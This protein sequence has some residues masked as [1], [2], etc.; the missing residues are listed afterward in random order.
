MFQEFNS[1]ALAGAP[2]QAPPRPAPQEAR[3]LVSR[4]PNLSEIELARL[5]NLYRRFS[6]LD[7]ALMISDDAVGPKLDRFVKDHRRKVRS[8]FSHYAFLVAYA[9]I[10]VAAVAWS[11]FK[12]M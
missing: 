11:F 6:A 1:R 2:A 4:Y 7:M 8:P 9:V 12:A 10:A 5:I 3:E